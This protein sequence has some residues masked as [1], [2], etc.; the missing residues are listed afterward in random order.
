MQ[1][2]QP[3]GIMAGGR[4]PGTPAFDLKNNHQALPLLE[5]GLVF[6]HCREIGGEGERPFSVEEIWQARQNLKNPNIARVDEIFDAMCRFGNS[7]KKFA[8]FSLDKPLIM[9]IVN[10]TPDSFSDGG[11]FSDENSAIDQALRLIDAGADLIDIGGESTRPGA[12]EVQPITEWQRVAPVIKQLIRRNI[13][14]SIDTRH[15]LVM[16]KAWREG[17]RIL[18]DVSGFNYDPCARDIAAKSGL[19]VIIMHMRGTPDSM[20]IAPHYDN[21][22]Y[23]ICTELQQS[24]ELAIKSGIKRENMMIDPGLGFAKNHEHNQKL[25]AGLAAVHSLGLPILLGASRK[26]LSDRPHKAPLFHPENPIKSKPRRIGSSLAA[27]I[28]GLQ[29]GC[30]MFRVH[31]VRETSD[32]IAVWDVIA[33][34]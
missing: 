3:L 11:E 14:I 20:N 8:G 27:V 6:T 12:A 25:L 18:N 33:N 32:A 31:D 34:S 29:S 22:I 23:E 21:V 4:R 2:Y 9:G 13:P 28:Q 1:I 16:E 17:V 26:G 15:A 7:A 10:V 30:Q 19:P 5:N 24:L